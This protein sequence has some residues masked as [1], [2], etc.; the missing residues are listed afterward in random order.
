MGKITKKEL[1]NVL[2]RKFESKPFDAYE[3]VGSLFDEIIERVSKGDI[4][5]IRGFGTLKS[6]GRKAKKVRDIGRGLTIQ[7]PAHKKPIFKAS[8]DFIN[9]CNK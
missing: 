6:V 7:M 5:E 2:N 1:A 4:M 9:L 8:K 3:I